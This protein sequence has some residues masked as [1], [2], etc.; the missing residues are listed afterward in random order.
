MFFQSERTES[1]NTQMG[2]LF[3]YVF[4]LQLSYNQFTTTK[5]DKTLSVRGSEEE[6]THST[7]LDCDQTD[8]LVRK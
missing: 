3:H 1:G 5:R 7:L 6:N 2:R 8:C 4:D